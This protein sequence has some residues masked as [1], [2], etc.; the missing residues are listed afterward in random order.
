MAG[1][2]PVPQR[3]LVRD[4]NRCDLGKRK[5]IGVTQ[6]SLRHDLAA[7]IFPNS[8]T[9]RHH[10]ENAKRGDDFNAP[11]ARSRVVRKE[12]LIQVLCDFPRTISAR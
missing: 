12:K 1:G 2:H 11:A 10:G 5:A 6:T 4:A 8:H 7:R 3:R 9:K